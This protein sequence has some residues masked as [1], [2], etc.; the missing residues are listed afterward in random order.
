MLRVDLLEVDDEIV[1][2]CRS[3][4]R[5]LAYV[6]KVWR[7]ADQLFE[8]AVKITSTFG[9]EAGGEVSEATIAHAYFG[10]CVPRRLT[11][12]LTFDHAVPHTL[13]AY[14]HCRLAEG[15]KRSRTAQRLV[16]DRRDHRIAGQRPRDH[17]Y[18]LGCSAEA[19]ERVSDPEYGAWRNPGDRNASQHVRLRRHRSAE[20]RAGRPGELIATWFRHFYCF[21][22]CCF[23]PAQRLFAVVRRLQIGTFLRGEARCQYLEDENVSEEEVEEGDDGDDDLG[24]HWLVETV[25]ALVSVIAEAAG[26][27]SR[28][29]LE[30][31]LPLLPKCF[32]P[33][34][35]Y[36]ARA[37]LIHALDGLTAAM[38]R[39]MVEYLPSLIP[40]IEQGL[41]DQLIDV[42]YVTAT[43]LADLCYAVEGAI[44]PV[45]PTLLQ[46]TW[47]RATS[48]ASRVC[49]V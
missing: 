16:Q 11:P 32:D 22:F 27:H 5:A 6:A 33:E 43:L 26:E 45:F 15:A 7:D 13:H 34:G 18:G 48:A 44:S 28:P 49:A 47:R 36:L 20:R 37:H 30:L 46:V 29:Y 10:A 41:A 40:I 24:P 39:T 42:R 1:E 2:A 19:L 14:R 8:F 25:L 17:R 35:L 31:V 9:S 38:G 3:A 21:A 12:L 4:A 23:S